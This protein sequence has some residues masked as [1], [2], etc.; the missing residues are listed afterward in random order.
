[1][2]NARPHIPHAEVAGKSQPRIA[3]IPICHWQLIAPLR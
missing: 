1:M 2:H 3:N